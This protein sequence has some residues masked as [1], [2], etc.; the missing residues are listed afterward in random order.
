VLVAKEENILNDAIYDGRVT[1]LPGD[2]EA[3]APDA[4]RAAG[5]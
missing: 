2:P 4:V 1:W 3:E 5:I